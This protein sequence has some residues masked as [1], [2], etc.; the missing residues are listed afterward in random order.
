MKTGTSVR[1]SGDTVTTVVTLLAMT[2]LKLQYPNGDSDIAAYTVTDSLDLAYGGDGVDTLINIERIEFADRDY[3]LKIRD[4]SS[5][6][7]QL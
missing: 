4:I 1:S 5:E 3:N 7:G 6:L 2:L